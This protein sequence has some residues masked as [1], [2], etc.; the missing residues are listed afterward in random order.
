MDIIVLHK[1]QGVS[2]FYEDRCE[3]SSDLVLSSCNRIFSLV[4]LL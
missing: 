3:T 2:F 1:V 4:V